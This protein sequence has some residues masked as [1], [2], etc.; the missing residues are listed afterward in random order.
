[1]QVAKL[2]THRVDA[3]HSQVIKAKP[4]PETAQGHWRRKQYRSAPS[5]RRP[6]RVS[7]CVSDPTDVQAPLQS[8]DRR[9]RCAAAARRCQSETDAGARASQAGGKEVKEAQGGEGSSSAR[10]CRATGQPMDVRLAGREEGGVNLRQLQHHVQILVFIVVVASHLGVHGHGWPQTQRQGRMCAARG[11]PGSGCDAVE[12]PPPLLRTLLCGIC[13][14][15]SRDAVY[16]QG[17]YQ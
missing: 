10:W 1:M 11:G 2:R 7:P 17:Q 6:P 14:E 15:P 16:V 9:V 12:P 8:S 5:P 13:R 3:V 4:S